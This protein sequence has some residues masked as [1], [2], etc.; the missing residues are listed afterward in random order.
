MD[1]QALRRIYAR[2]MLA[3][4]NA[5]GDQALENAFA[6]VPRE[7]FLGSG[8]WRIMTPWSP[9]VLVERRDPALIY[10][11]VV[12]AL[13]ETRG[14]NNGSPSL[15]AHWMHSAAPRAG[16][17]VAHIGAGT[18]YYTAILAAMV[19]KTGRV[20]AVEFDP[21]RAARAGENLKNRRNVEVVQ[22]DGRAWPR[23]AADVVYVNFASSRPA[24]AWI[25]NLTPGGRLIFPLGVPRS[26]PGIRSGLNALALM[27]ERRTEGFAA[28]ALG[29]VS[30]VFAE[31]VEAQTAGEVESLQVRLEDGDWSQIRSLVWG[32]Q[33]DSERCWHSGAGWALGMD[34]P[35]R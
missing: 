19:G 22:G 35:S 31:G 15:H 17:S 25:E 23:V 20:T 27:I 33:V 21:A 8:A 9:Y 18:G 6:D 24:A 10:Q 11:D 7:D 14:I 12:V 34:D 16:E 4:A 5:S 29:L 32:D 2:Q 28:K 30:F 26:G 13:D 1:L 3:L